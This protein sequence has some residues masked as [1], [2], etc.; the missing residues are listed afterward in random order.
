[1]VAGQRV[2]GAV[3]VAHRTGQPAVGGVDGQPV[4]L[5]LVEQGG[6][7][8]DDGREHLRELLGTL[9]V[10]GERHRAS[11]RRLAGCETRSVRAGSGPL[12]QT[13]PA[14]DDLGGVVEL[15]LT[16]HPGQLALQP[17]RDHRL[18]DGEH[19]HLVVGEQAAFHRVA[20]RQPVKLRAESGL[21]I[22]RHQLGGMLVGLVLDRVGEN[23]WGGRHVQ[24]PR[25]PQ[26][27]A[28]VH[29]HEVRL[30]LTGQ[31]D[32]GAAVRLVAFTE[33]ARLCRA[34]F[35]RD[36][37]HGHVRDMAAFREKSDSNHVRSRSA[38]R[39]EMEP[40]MLASFSTETA[41]GAVR[42]T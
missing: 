10:A 4:V 35:V 14:A 33:R 7:G 30:V 1:M 5:Q 12:G 23:P 26:V 11:H 9:D 18:V 15:Q 3:H 28:V 17:R 41:S 20:E 8:V 31:R 24:P 16:G 6:V 25:G 39:T 38:R 42:I 27:A 34:Q 13:V 32:P 2:E 21:V 36:W 19:Q 37:C 40:G 22:H 29:P